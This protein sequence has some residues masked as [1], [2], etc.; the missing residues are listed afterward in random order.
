MIGLA[1]NLLFVELGGFSNNYYINRLQDLV[2]ERYDI[3]NY[4]PAMQK[5]DFDALN[6]YLPNRFDRL[7]PLLDPLIQ[8]L[9]AQSY[10]HILLP[11]ITLHLGLDKLGLDK[12]IQGQFIHPFVLAEKEISN[13]NIKKIT[14]LGTRYAMQEGIFDNYF[15]QSGI[16]ITHPEESDSAIIDNLR[17]EVCKNGSSPTLIKSFELMLAKYDSP[18]LCCTELSILNQGK[19]DVIDLAELQMREVLNLLKEEF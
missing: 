11:N 14:I 10:P 13:R 12:K 2:L 18:L 5:V 3:P 6:Q 8:K 16:R 1:S 4:R 15:N 19:S 17:Q 9:L 7:L